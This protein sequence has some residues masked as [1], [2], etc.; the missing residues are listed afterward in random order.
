GVTMRSRVPSA[1]STMADGPSALKPPITITGLGF[2]MKCAPSCSPITRSSLASCM[3]RR[4]SASRSSNVMRALILLQ[5]GRIAEV[6]I[7]EQLFER[8]HLTHHALL[9]HVALDRLQVRPV[10][11]RQA[12]LPRIAPERRLLLLDRGAHPGERHHARVLH[13]AISHL[14]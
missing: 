7:L 11:G 9:V 13:A 12:I 3:R 4:I 1:C 14:L 2:S 5:A 8:P 10:R 6:G